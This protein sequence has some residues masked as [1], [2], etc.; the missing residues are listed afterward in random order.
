MSLITWIIFGGI[1]GWIAS[2]IMGKNHSMGVLANVIVGIIGAMV[3]GA[4]AGMMGLEG[5]SGFNMSSFIVAMAGSILLI[6]VINLFERGTD[7]N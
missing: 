7:V 1:V 2:M 6:A 4:I 5:V 3:G